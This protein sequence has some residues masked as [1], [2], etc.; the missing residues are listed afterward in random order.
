MTVKVIGE[1]VHSLLGNCDWVVAHEVVN[2]LL[3]E[4]GCF[5]AIKKAIIGICAVGGVNCRFIV[6]WIENL[7]EELGWKCCLGWGEGRDDRGSV[8]A[9]RVVLGVRNMGLMSG[10][11]SVD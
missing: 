4:I 5:G 6:G 8:V 9:W 1:V 2:I 7:H 3:G 11:T 10:K